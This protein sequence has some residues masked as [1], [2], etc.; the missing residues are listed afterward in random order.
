[1]QANNSNSNLNS[2]AYS[3][4]ERK[5]IASENNNNNTLPKF[6]INNPNENSTLFKTHINR[7]LTKPFVTNVIP[8]N[9]NKND[10]NNNP[11]FLNKI[12]RRS[13]KNNKIVFCH[14]QKNNTRKF[15]NGIKVKKQKIKNKIKSFK[16][17]IINLIFNSNLNLNIYL[18]ESEEELKGEDLIKLEEN[19]DNSLSDS[20]NQNNSGKDEN[21]NNENNNK[22]PRGSRYRGVSRNGNQWQV[23]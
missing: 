6:I 18:K 19:L 23:K 13:I 12:R 8:L 17:N 7:I 11:D 9:G 10:P 15:I 5:N 3:L 16:T 14:S 4:E 20:N 22:K 1:M 2:G 21:D